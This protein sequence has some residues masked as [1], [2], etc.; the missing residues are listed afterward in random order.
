MKL[1]ETQTG[2]QLK[3]VRTDNG[4]EYLNKNLQE[5]FAGKGVVH[6]TTT[7]YTP[8]QNGAAE[9][10]NR[11]LEERVRAMLIGAGLKKELWAEAVVTA[12]Y[13][14][15][16]S[17]HAR[18]V[19]VPWELF[20]GHKPDVSGLRVFGARAFVL[21]PK[22]L[23]SKLDPVSQPGVFVGYSVNSKAYRVLLDAT[24]KIVESRDV[25][26]N[27]TDFQASSTGGIVYISD[28][29][30]K[31]VM[32]PP[33]P[34][35]SEEPGDEEQLESHG[36]GM[37]EEGELRGA[38]RAREREE[39]TAAEARYPRRDRQA[40]GTWYVANAATENNDGVPTT[41]EEALS[42]PAAD[43]WRAAMDEEMA[44]LHKNQTW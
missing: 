20:Y 1:L 5:Y 6:Q 23:R 19:K 34:A 41:A 33:T 24:G 25:T 12:N 28:E 10:L 21:T 16:R 14:R 18:T 26:I 35:A 22:Q 40:P 30:A 13:I 36:S 42:G 31:Q 32:A 17:P 9:R 8:E 27:E 38:P 43:L 37:T 15:N 7:P 44:S 4:G 11:V 3:A 29:E 39:E 2:Q